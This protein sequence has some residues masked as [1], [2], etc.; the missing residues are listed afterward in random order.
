MSGFMKCLICVF[1]LLTVGVGV[2]FGQAP[3]PTGQTLGVNVNVSFSQVFTGTWMTGQPYN[4]VT[5]SPAGA[6]TFAATG[7]DIDGIPG[8][9][10][11]ASYRFVRL[12]DDLPNQTD[13]PFGEAD[14]DAVEALSSVPVPAGLWLLASALLALFAS[15]K[16]ST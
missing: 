5:V 9:I 1:V 12:T 7:I 2:S 10:A 13:S 15:R 3:C 11:G 8:V 14:I 6:E 4:I 16:R